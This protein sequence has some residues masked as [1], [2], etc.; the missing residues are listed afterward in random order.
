MKA[1]L[2]ARGRCPGCLPA[3]KK[4]TPGACTERIA[5]TGLELY[6]LLVT[7]SFVRGSI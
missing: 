7:V 2:G 3:G 4:H 1:A 6:K 5:D